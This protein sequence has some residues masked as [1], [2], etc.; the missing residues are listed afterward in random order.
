MLRFSANISMMFAEH[1]FEARPGAARRA[2]FDGVEFLFPYGY[3]CAQLAGA[4]EANALGL[5]VFN[6]PPGDW[7]Q[8]ERGLA[9]LKGREAEFAESVETAAAYARALKAERVHCMAGIAEGAAAEACFVDN[10]RRA[11]DRLAQQGCT[12]MI[13]PINAYDMPGYF[14]SRTDQALGLLER[15]DHENVALQWDIYHHRR[16]HGPA[17]DMLADVMSRVEHIQIAGLPGRHEPEDYGEIFAAL[18]A[19]GYAGWIG[20]EYG[21]AGRTE[22]GLEWLKEARERTDE[23][24]A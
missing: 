8:G 9:A 10:L 22:D 17:L 6:L 20:C 19:A 18:D 23:T 1:P 11:A 5:S 16:T 3:D 7:A 14:L 12:V 24:G 15:I 21:P 4:L 2:G 13:E